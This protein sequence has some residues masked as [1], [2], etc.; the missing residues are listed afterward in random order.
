MALDSDFWLGAATS[1]VSAEGATE[2]SDWGSWERLGRLPGSAAGNGF[3]T[4][5]RDDLRLL[6]QA[7]VGHVRLGVEWARI[8]PENGVVDERAVEHYQQVL[9]AADEAGLAVWVTLVSR[10]L[11]GWFAIDEHGWRDRRSRTF[12][13]PRHVER[14]AELFGEWAYA[15]VPITRPMTTARAAY[16]TGAAPPGRRDPFRFTD[17]ILSTHQAALEAWRVLRGGPPVAS[18]FDLAAMR[19]ADAEPTTRSRTRRAESFLWCW[20]DGFRD[21]E[22]TLEGQGLRS[23]PTMPD[24]FDLV[25]VTIEHRITVPERGE[26]RRDHRPEDVG[27]ILQRVAEQGP[28]RPVVVLGQHVA[29]VDQLDEV[30]G[31]V[32][33]ARS[34]GIDVRG[35]FAEPMIDGYE[36]EDGFEPERGLF[37]VERAPRPVLERLRDI[38]VGLAEPADEFEGAVLLTEGARPS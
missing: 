12:S 15:W 22:L 10:S 38:A 31:L 28:D 3:A 32:D 36:W 30:L 20:T 5:Y 34:G 26:W 23:V 7:G 2:A 21:G 18:C 13:W 35:W 8:E 19:P 24:A 37:D 6:G 29:T 27:E 33:D 25:G 1:S 11:P 14:C 17:A 4:R 16:L 9:A